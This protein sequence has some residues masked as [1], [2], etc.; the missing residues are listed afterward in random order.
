MKTIL[1]IA[2]I[3]FYIIFNGFVSHITNRLTTTPAFMQDSATLKNQRDLFAVHDAQKIFLRTN[4]NKKISAVLIERPHA[5]SSLIIC[6][7]YRRNKEHI[8]PFINLFPDYNLL[9]LDFRGHGESEKT[10]I[11]FGIHEYHDVL[12]A[13]KFMKNRFP[14]H[15]L[16]GLG[17]SMGGAALLRAVVEG[18][19]FDKIIIDSS[20][21][22]LLDTLTRALQLRKF[23][24][25]IPNFTIPF[26]LSSFE[27]AVNGELESMNLVKHLPNINI[28]ALIMHDEK[29]EVCPF[30]YA[31]NTY[32]L[33]GGEKYLYTFNGTRHA[34]AFCDKPEEYARAVST[35][36][37]KI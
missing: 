7:S 21:N 17:I 34:Y 26:I 31:Q 5:Q 20:F 30:A 6:H 3:A 37:S 12:A 4:D 13:T 24:E 36:I 8:A 18:A 9:L 2:A 32:D 28:S 35:F 33:L 25:I 11:S 22:N 1:A 27:R 10:P 23:P 15:L 19:S 29:D 14:D 16:I